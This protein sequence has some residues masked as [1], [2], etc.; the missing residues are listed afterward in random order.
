VSNAFWVF[1]VQSLAWTDIGDGLKGSRPPPAVDFGMVAVDHT[2]YI[3]GGAVT[4][5]G[6]TSIILR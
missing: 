3:F 4:T 2:I 1:G 5:G 6:Y